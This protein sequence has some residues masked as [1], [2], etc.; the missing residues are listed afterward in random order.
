MTAVLISVLLSAP[1]PLDLRDLMVSPILDM[2]VA[3]SV[4]SMLSLIIF[5]DSVVV[6][7]LL[8]VV[9]CCAVVIGCIN[10]SGGV[11]VHILLYIFI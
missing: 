1:A 7:C 11:C 6:C 10:G 4:R 5:V 9:L 8:F 2:R 3:S